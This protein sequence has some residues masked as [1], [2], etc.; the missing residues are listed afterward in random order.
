[1]T[2]GIFYISCKSECMEGGY[3]IR[4]V[5]YERTI[6]IRM[7]GRFDFGLMQAFAAE[8]RQATDSYQ[9]GDH[10]VLA[11]MR[12][13]APLLPEVGHVFGA[14][15]GYARAHGVVCCAHISDD[16]TQKWQAA[17]LARQDKPANDVTMNFASMDEALGALETIRKQ[18]RRSTAPPPPSSGTHQAVPSEGL[19]AVRVPRG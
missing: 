18:F 7:T 9:G 2:I 8:Y 6:Y 16:A 11:D 4:N 10:L 3:S 1:M 5:A 15:V 13:L 17:R 12:G 19:K 14:A